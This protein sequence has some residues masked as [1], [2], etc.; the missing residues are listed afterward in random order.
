LLQRAPRDRFSDS[1]TEPPRDGFEQDFAAP[2]RSRGRWTPHLVILL[3]A[4][5]AGSAALW[6]L[7]GG[8]L[9]SAPA[10]RLDVASETTQAVEDQ[11]PPP[12]P[13]QPSADQF[14]ALQQ[15]LA[16]QQAETRRLSDKVAA[17]SGKVDALQQ[18][19]ASTAVPVAK[20]TPPRKKPPAA[21]APAPSTRWSPFG[22]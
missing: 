18:S 15:D 12:P 8:G 20:A 21:P 3:V 9:S 14:Q 16:D 2:L 1:P 19:F 5:A 4:V 6:D 11:T 13:Q 10:P 22:Q 17:L 7:Y